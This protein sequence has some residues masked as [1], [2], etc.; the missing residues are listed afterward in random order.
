MAIEY[1][2]KSCNK[3]YKIREYAQL[4]ILYSQDIFTGR[5]CNSCGME[6]GIDDK[7]VT[8]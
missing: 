7:N 6:I 1:Q 3:K 2:C 4:E 8:I 5:K